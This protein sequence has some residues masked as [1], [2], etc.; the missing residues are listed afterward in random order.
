MQLY[1]KAHYNNRILFFRTERAS[2]LL[3]EAGQSIVRN[4]DRE[5]RFRDANKLSSSVSTLVT[6]NTGRVFSAIIRWPSHLT[7]LG[8][9]NK[10]SYGR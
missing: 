4:K 10:L 5:A 1:S 6:P 9:Q 2:I 8:H 7:F 3:F